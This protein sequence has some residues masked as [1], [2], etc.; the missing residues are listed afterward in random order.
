MGTEG[1]FDLVME[2]NE[3]KEKID[4]ALKTVQRIITSHPNVVLSE[5]DL[6]RLVSS[7]ISH[8]IREKNYSANNPF[9]VHTQISH[10]KKNDETGL[11]TQLD[12]RVDILLL[13]ENELQICLKNHK[14][15]KYDGDSI[16]LEL[17]YLHIGEG[18]ARIKSDLYKKNIINNHSWLYL[19]ILLDAYDET[20][21]EKKKKAF[22]DLIELES[23][24]T[25]HIYY[26]I[27]M[28]P[29]IKI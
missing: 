10:Y 27:L 20:S 26:H 13:K 18:A 22:E 5:A 12:K 23:K 17:K 21:F 8:E 24:N 15:Y 16:A 6:E 29:I 9:S 1:G 19:V 4:L 28:K 7:C 3:L 14:L 2:L 25:E 11:S